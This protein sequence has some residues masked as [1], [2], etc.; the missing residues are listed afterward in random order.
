MGNE[1]AERDVWEPHDD[2]SVSHM[3]HRLR[4]VPNRYTLPDSEIAGAAGFFWANLRVALDATYPGW[5]GPGQGLSTAHPPSYESYEVV[6]EPAKV[7]VTGWRKSCESAGQ[8]NDI[9]VMTASFFDGSALECWH[10]LHESRGQANNNLLRPRC[11][12]RPRRGRAG[13]ASTPCLRIHGFGPVGHVCLETPFLASMWWVDRLARVGQLAGQ[14]LPPAVRQRLTVRP[15]RGCVAH[16]SRGGKGN[17]LDAVSGLVGVSL[18][19]SV[20]DLSE[21]WTIRILVLLKPTPVSSAVPL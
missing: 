12:T 20:Q 7:V 2:G 15:G 3:R 5:S 16:C 9:R 13:P 14:L 11:R 6:I 1:T 18:D 17:W 8:A 4:V 19:A 21:G 10:K